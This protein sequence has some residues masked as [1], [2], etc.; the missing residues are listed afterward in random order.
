[1]NELFAQFFACVVKEINGS[2]LAVFSKL[3][4]LQRPNFVPNSVAIKIILIFA[5]PNPTNH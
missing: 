2:V 1:M 5:R 4:T 3:T